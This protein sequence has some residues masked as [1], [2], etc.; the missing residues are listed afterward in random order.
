[1]CNAGNNV[2]TII[3]LQSI[4]EISPVRLEESAWFASGA[5]F[6]FCK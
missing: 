5:F 3:G 4:D 2:E 6:L 1:M